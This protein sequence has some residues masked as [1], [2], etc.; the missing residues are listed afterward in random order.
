M[1][2]TIEVPEVPELSEAYDLAMRLIWEHYRER[3]DV[4]E[5]AN[6]AQYPGVYAVEFG[7]W[8]LEA[9]GHRDES[10]DD[11]LPYRVRVSHHGL[12]VGELTASGGG[13]PLDGSIIAAMHLARASLRQ[14]TERRVD[15]RQGDK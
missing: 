15:D 5:F 3:V 1:T 9:H 11:L 12:L 4:R 7:C 6:L 13:P 8:T 2:E 10:I 14:A